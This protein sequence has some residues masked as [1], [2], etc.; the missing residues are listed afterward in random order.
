MKK[1]ITAM[2]LGVGA[3]VANAAC[4]TPTLN[5]QLW[6]TGGECR[7]PDSDAEHP[8]VVDRQWQG[9][10]GEYCRYRLRMGR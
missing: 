4:P 9:G 2:S 6:W 8:I 3:M 5:T 1:I 10:T 7:L